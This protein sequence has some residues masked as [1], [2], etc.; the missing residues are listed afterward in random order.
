M[1]TESSTRL[2]GLRPRPCQRDRC[3]R[4]GPARQAPRDRGARLVL[5]RPRQL[6]CELPRRAGSLGRLARHPALERLGHRRRRGRPVLADVGRRRGGDRVGDRDGCLPVARAAPGER[7]VTDGGERVDVDR[8]TGLAPLELLGRH[9]GGGA[10]D[11]AAARDAGR[12]GRRGD[13]EVDELRDRI[14]AQQ[15]IRRLDVAVHDA[16]GM[17]VVERGAQLTCHA[18]HPPGPQRP[19]AERRCERLARHVLHDDENALIVDRGVVDRDEVRMVQRGSELRLAN[20]A[21]L[22]VGRAVGMQ[23]LDR[24]LT[25]E[26]LV[27]AQQHG[28]H[29]PGAQMPEHAVA[30]GQKRALRRNRHPAGVPALPAGLTGEAVCYRRL[31]GAG[32][33]CP[34]RAR[35]RSTS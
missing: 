35:R 7:L 26:A 27:P 18:R 5:E 9:V 14:V 25:V 24:D 29:S 1:L 17:R 8:G 4:G 28:R 16:L 6:G 10:E 31:K 11:G 13:A 32:S 12:V 33:A 34:C 21:L 2:R 19:M 20:E 30:P 15:D 3:R 23:S 22:G